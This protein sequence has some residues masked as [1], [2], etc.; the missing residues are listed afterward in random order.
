[1][2]E[3]IGTY[4][5]DFEDFYNEKSDTLANMAG[6]LTYRGTVL[7]AADWGGNEEVNGSVVDLPLSALTSERKRVARSDTGCESPPKRNGKLPRPKTK[8]TLKLSHRPK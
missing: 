7:S 6:G 2:V 5:L 4:G 3:V 8:L 1:M